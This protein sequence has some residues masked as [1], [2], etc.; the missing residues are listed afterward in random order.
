MRLLCEEEC[1]V[2]LCLRDDG[3]KARKGRGD[4]A[5]ARVCW[6]VE[7]SGACRLQSSGFMPGSEGLTE[8]KGVEW[9][10]RKVQYRSFVQPAGVVACSS[11]PGLFAAS[12]LFH[13]P[14]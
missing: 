1:D 2:Y 8:G 14:K 11:P 5:Q 13:V 9:K 4:M 7:R 10:Y 6:E 3:T 12:L